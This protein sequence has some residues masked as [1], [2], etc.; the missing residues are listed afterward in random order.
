MVGYIILL[1]ASLFIIGSDRIGNQILLIVITLIPVV[2]L[3]YAMAGVVQNARQQDEMKRR[4]HYEAVLV[5][6]LLTGG[7]TFSYGLLERA[8]I[9][10]PV[11]LVVIAPFMIVAWGISRFLISHRYDG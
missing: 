2:P 5:T 1:P 9:V 8:G 7:L 4:I 11:S 10:P 3:L 6:A